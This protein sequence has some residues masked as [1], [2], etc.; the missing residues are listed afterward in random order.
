MAEW[1]IPQLDDCGAW[2]PEHATSDFNNT[3]PNTPPVTELF[4][5]Y[6]SGSFPAVYQVRHDLR[7]PRIAGLTLPFT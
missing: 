5:Y 1:Y 4:Q 7:L 3:A 2:P 6:P